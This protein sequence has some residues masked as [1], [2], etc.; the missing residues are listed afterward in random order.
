MT[1]LELT[2]EQ[3][4]LVL[5]FYDMRQAAAAARLLDQ[6]SPVA[7]A[8][9]A[10]ETAMSVCYA[11]SWKSNTK[12]R[13]EWLPAVGP[14]RDLHHRLLELRTKTHAHNDPAGGRTGSVQVGLDGTVAIVEQWTPPDP[15]EWEA[16]ADL[17]DRQADRFER[18][19]V[20]AFSAS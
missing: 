9:R 20:D 4:R 2:D 3:R 1:D 17:C 16:V 6:H 18:A 12:L 10:L 14:D 7:H 11:R 8:R 15:N 19:L 13:K 5:A